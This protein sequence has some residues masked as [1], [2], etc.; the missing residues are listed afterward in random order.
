[1]S[2]FGR[3]AI[4]F[5]YRVRQQLNQ[6]LCL[7]IAVRIA[8]AVWFLEVLGVPRGTIIVIS[9]VRKVSR[10]ISVDFG[11][12]GGDVVGRA[13]LNMI[14]G[15]PSRSCWIDN[16][17]TVSGDICKHISIT[18]IT[19][20][21]PTATNINQVKGKQSRGCGTE[22]KHVMCLGVLLSKKE[23][24]I[25][26]VLCGCAVKIKLLLSGIKVRVI[27][28]P[29]AQ[30]REWLPNSKAVVGLR[31]QKFQDSNPTLSPSLL[32]PGSP[33]ADLLES[34]EALENTIIT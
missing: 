1:M 30:P 20:V 2:L 17:L 24:V 19:I 29:G 26:S 23:K 12:I 22:L 8:D 28:G 9:G 21:L 33:T 15:T 11:I 16:H 13:I 25:P 4:F 27:Q 34:S 14:W 5:P 3:V 31:D 10:I 6:F 32:I 7:R 18:G